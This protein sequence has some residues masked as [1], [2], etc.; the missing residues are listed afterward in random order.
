[1]YPLTLRLIQKF[2]SKKVHGNFHVVHAAR[3]IETNSKILYRKGP[4][5]VH[6]PCNSETCVMSHA[7]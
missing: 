1:M 2:L 5:N 3:T 4:W 6:A 7:S